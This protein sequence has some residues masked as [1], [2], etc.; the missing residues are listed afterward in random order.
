MGNRVW[1]KKGN[2]G[3]STLFIPHQKI[4]GVVLTFSLKPEVDERRGQGLDLNYNED[5]RPSKNRQEAGSATSSRIAFNESRHCRND[6]RSSGYLVTPPPSTTPLHAGLDPTII[7]V[8]TSPVYRERSSPEDWAASSY[9]VTPPSAT[10]ALPDPATGPIKSTLLP[11]RQ[12]EFCPPQNHRKYTSPP[13]HPNVQSTTGLFTPP[14]SASPPPVMRSPDYIMIPKSHFASEAYVWRPPSEEEVVDSP[15]YEDLPSPV[16]EDV[17]SPSYSPIPTLSDPGT[18]PPI[19]LEVTVETPI[20]EKN[21]DTMVS[22]NTQVAEASIRPPASRQVSFGIKRPRPRSPVGNSS[23]DRPLAK[24]QSLPCMQSRSS[25]RSDSPMTPPPDEE[26]LEEE[27]NDEEVGRFDEDF[28]D[29]N[30]AG[31]MAN[32]EDEAELEEDEE[33]SSSRA[34]PSPPPSLSHYSDFD[35]GCEIGCQPVE[36]DQEPDVS[37]TCKISDLISK[38]VDEI[39]LKTFDLGKLLLECDITDELAGLLD[40]WI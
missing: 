2:G 35:S 25:S 18:P 29:G 21:E 32:E 7:K 6:S 17:A 11:I 26:M 39:D 9:I 24:R 3:Y 38:S 19:G 23:D 15:K 28:E 4:D 27:E 8:P 20:V 5:E 36:F 40:V 30:N 33:R 10:I 16:N 22:V 13:I 1:K 37:S 34:S 31:V 14:S 12:I